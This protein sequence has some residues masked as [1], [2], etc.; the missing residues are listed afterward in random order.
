MAFASI[1]TAGNLTATTKTGEHPNINTS[2]LISNKS[3]NRYWTLQ[4]N[5]IVFSNYTTLFNFLTSDIDAS[6]NYNNL[7][8]G[9]YVA[10]WSYPSIGI[11]TANS[12]TVNGLTAFGD[13]QLAEII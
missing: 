3:V 5:G 8:S 2:V 4:N 7:K 1:T 13:F 12:T 11:A 10:A 6:A 9:N